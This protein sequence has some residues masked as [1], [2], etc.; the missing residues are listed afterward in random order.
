MFEMFC[1]NGGTE[2]FH[3][4]KRMTPFRAHHSFWS[5]IHKST[6]IPVL[7]HKIRL[8]FPCCTLLFKESKH[9][10]GH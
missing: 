1:G 2:M 6:V 5:T 7:L 10:F 9:K 3:E 8:S 4:H